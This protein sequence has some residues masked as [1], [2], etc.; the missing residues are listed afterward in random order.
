MSSTSKKKKATDLPNIE[1]THDVSPSSTS[2]NINNSND[3]ATLDA[4]NKVLAQMQIMQAQYNQLQQC[5]IELSERKENKRHTDNLI[6]INQPITIKDEPDTPQLESLASPGTATTIT[7]ASDASSSSLPGKSSSTSKQEVST[8]YVVH[9]AIDQISKGK[10]NIN[11]LS[12]GAIITHHG[13]IMQNGKKIKPD[14]L[15]ETDMRAIATNNRTRIHTLSSKED[16][17][18]TSSVL[19]SIN[20]AWPHDLS[21]DS[22]SLS[23]PKFEA[24]N[25]HSAANFIAWQTNVV[26]ECK[27][28]GLQDILLKPLD[29]I[30]N[31]IMKVDFSIGNGAS[32]EY[33]AAIKAAII[34]SAYDL[35][36][37]LFYLLKTA[38]QDK[39]LFVLSKLQT[40]ALIYESNVPQLYIEGNCNLLWRA[41]DENYHRIT[42]AAIE[43]ANRAF[44]SISYGTGKRGST[45][46]VSSAATQSLI[47]AIYNANRNLAYVDKGRS[48]AALKSLLQ[49]KLPTELWNIIQ[50][51][52][53]N[54]RLEDMSYNDMCKLILDHSRAIEERQSNLPTDRSA[55]NHVDVKGNKQAS[56]KEGSATKCAKCNSITHTTKDH[57][58]CSRCKKAHHPDRCR[59]DKGKTGAANTN[60]TNGSGKGNSNH[61]GQQNNNNK[62]STLYSCNVSVERNSAGEV[63]QVNYSAGNVNF[64]THLQC[65]FDT[66]GAAH[67]AC[68]D[69]HLFDIIELEQPVFITLPDGAEIKVTHCGSMM[70]TPDLVL[71]RVLYVPK[72]RVNI[73]SVAL[74]TDRGMNVK[75]NSN[76]CQLRAVEENGELGKIL[77]TAKRN[78]GNIYVHTLPREPF[79]PRRP[80]HGNNK[81]KDLVKELASK[82]KGAN[83]IDANGQPS[84][85]PTTV[86][87]KVTRHIPKKK[88]DVPGGPNNAKADGNN[89][90]T[91]SSSSAPVNA[92][93]TSSTTEGTYN[94]NAD[95]DSE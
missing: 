42:P 72:F 49:L 32:E 37:Q 56:K 92:V 63:V 3:S 57:Y 79:E 47:V 53:V 29:Y 76:S 40:D 50:A 18:L 95:S 22:F 48:E 84:N 15:R 68:N 55:L 65:V 74:L 12:T 51:V 25:V 86:S 64:N 75:F 16:K 45:S 27:R 88:Q 7:N 83:Y 80:K 60:T 26:D 69:S 14:V 13:A 58:D 71:N 70:L 67:A 5:Y 66:G 93:Q 77:L 52:T 38:V 91:S 36:K 89:A 61:K 62:D 21:L 1:D 54:N 78:D 30:T 4:L 24:G 31:E 44:D 81:K 46:Q 8:S 17:T 43:E 19:T 90:T 11:S 6:Q 82:P 9:S 2:S 87:I 85:K 39:E 59:L 34:R 33:T 94:T 23:I 20:I 73:I 10:N 28:V 41:L 35:S